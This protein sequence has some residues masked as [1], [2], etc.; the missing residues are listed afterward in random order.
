MQINTT[1]SG[2][3]FIFWVCCVCRGHLPDC[4]HQRRFWTCHNAG[5][6]ALR[7]PRTQEPDELQAPFWGHSMQV[8]AGALFCADNPLK[9]LFIFIKTIG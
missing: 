1:R 5:A 4:L 8:Q 3:C 7:R 6:G 9:S 2:G